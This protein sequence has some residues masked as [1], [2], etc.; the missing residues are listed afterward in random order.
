MSIDVNKKTKKNVTILH[1]CLEK[2]LCDIV[3]ILLSQNSDLVF[4]RGEVRN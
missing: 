3:K 4:C 1:I 2:G